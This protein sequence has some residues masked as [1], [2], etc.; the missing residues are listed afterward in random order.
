ML[1]DAAI[2][3]AGEERNAGMYGS[4]RVAEERDIRDMIVVRL[5]V[6]E[7]RLSDPGKLTPQMWLDALEQSG[8][9]CTWVCEVEGRIVGFS[10]ARIR[11]CDIWA[12]FVA[13]EFEGRGIG[14]HLLDLATNW[15]IEKGVKTIVLGTDQ[16][17]RA[18]SFYQ[19]KGWQRGET[20][21]NG[22]VVYQWHCNNP[23]KAR[24]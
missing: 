18:D 16:R 15:M 5:A 11:E 22:E 14:S 24:A 10:A 4:Y 3:G 13:P 6:V 1:T 23:A 21:A 12:L 20:K 8:S 17:S 7:N 9:A 2:M 19:A